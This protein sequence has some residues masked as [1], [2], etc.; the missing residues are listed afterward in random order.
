MTPMMDLI[1]KVR[2]TKELFEEAETLD[3]EE[4]R[5][6][7]TLCSKIGLDWLKTGKLQLVA[8]GINVGEGVQIAM[9][10]DDEFQVAL[11]EIVAGVINNVSAELDKI[12]V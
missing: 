3:P 5:G 10:P 2:L 12:E 1:V 11:D 6:N 8:G 7:P 9:P 4:Y